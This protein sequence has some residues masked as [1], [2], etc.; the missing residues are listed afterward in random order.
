MTTPATPADIATLIEAACLQRE[1][2]YAIHSGF[3]VGAALETVDGRLFTGCNIE[4]DSF[5]LSMCAERVAIFKA[6]SDGCREFRRMVVVATPLASPCGA[7]R[8]VMSQF[9]GDQT[10]IISVDA[11]N[12]EAHRFWTMNELLPDHFRFEK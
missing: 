5:G 2:A 7:C 8:Q 6:V 12:P 1:A 3:A 10:E 9:F 11:G 4:N